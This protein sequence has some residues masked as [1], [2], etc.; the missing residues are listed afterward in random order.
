MLFVRFAKPQIPPKSKG[1]GTVV[2]KVLT[3]GVDGEERRWIRVF[4]LRR[5]HFLCVSCI[6]REDDFQSEMTHRGHVRP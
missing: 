6:S 5:S 3:F 4:F 1:F 2:I